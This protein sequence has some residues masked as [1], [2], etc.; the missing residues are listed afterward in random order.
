M[1]RILYIMVLA[2]L[3]VQING[4]MF[5]Y[6]LFECNR[7]NIAANECERRTPDCC[8]KCYLTK[9]LNKQDDNSNTTTKVELA[10]PVVEATIPA[11]FTP[12]VPQSGCI[13]RQVFT[14]RELT[15]FAQ[16]TEHP[17]QFV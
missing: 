2:A 4:T 1:K 13:P 6:V 12:F 9:N 7:H 3:V 5:S 15:G 10:D 8:G 11:S 17:P 16:Q 14:A